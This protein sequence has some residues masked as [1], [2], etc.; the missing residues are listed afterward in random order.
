MS[1][2]NR[3]LEPE[4]SI[5]KSI[6]YRVSQFIGFLIGARVPATLLLTFALYVST[7]F[8]FNQEESL[9]NF[10]FDFKVHGIIFCSVLSILAGGIINQFYD[11]EKDQIIKPFRTRLQGFLKQ[12]Y[13]LYAY[14][15]LN[16]ISLGVA[17][18]ISH[19]VLL[20]FLGYQFM[21]WFYSHK[22]SRILI[23]NNLT[24]VALTLYPFFGMLVYY[25]TFSISVFVMAL[26]LFLILLCLD[27]IKDM[28]TKNADKIFNYHTIPNVFGEQITKILV[29]IL[30]LTLVLV[31]S[32]LFWKIGTE[33]VMSWYFF[34][35]NILFFLCIYWV[36]SHLKNSKF[37]TLNVLRI[38]VFVGIVMMLIDGI[39]LKY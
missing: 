18:L 5:T 17:T 25:Q 1:S 20:F 37:Y 38:W 16:L 32:L 6:F 9:R 36:I 26:F 13:F 19:R 11:K 39:L 33:R 24:F 14:I 2:E 27:I 4:N 22:L 15:L 21:M 28:L 35:G 23:L 7:F 10:V 30:F 3:N 29:T 31:S 8:L 34:V 12:N